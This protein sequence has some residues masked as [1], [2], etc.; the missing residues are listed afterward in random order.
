MFDRAIAKGRLRRTSRLL[1]FAAVW[2]A[3][4]GITSS[5]AELTQK[6]DL[7]VHFGGGIAPTAL[8]RSSPAPISV[9]IEGR[10]RVLAG[11]SPPSL[12]QITIAL[13]RAGRL[14]TVGLP[15]CHRGGIDSA[16]PSEALAACGPS[17]VGSGGLV[18]KIA[19]TNHEEA[20]A[21]A[22]EES[23]V[24][25]NILL[26]NGSSKGRP[27]IF[28]QVYQKSPPATY[29]IV[30]SVKRTAGTYGTVISGEV[31]PSVIRH[32]YLESIF[33]QLERRYTYRGK[34][35]SYLSANCGA[36]PGFTGAVFP[37]ARASMR[38]DD[39]RTLS[40]TLVRS[41]KVRG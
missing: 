37:F 35:R 17:L 21:Q 5:S 6:G 31:P 4:F 13:N 25:G 3:A 28:A 30:F 11:Q 16:D 15:V 26:F 7:F 24:R 36:P 29:L 27:A 8:P 34:P 12:R 41:C 33:L 2:I 39:D 1:L 38:F 23:R 18:A 10:I 22:S 32:G 14:D 40:S 9:R 19:I 20:P